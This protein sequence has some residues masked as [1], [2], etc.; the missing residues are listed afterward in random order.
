MHLRTFGCKCFVH[1]NGKDNLSKFDARSDEG[2][3][4]G[5]SSHSKAYKIYN[6]RTLCIEESA[7][8]IF[9]ESNVLHESDLQE[10][11]FDLELTRKEGIAERETGSNNQNGTCTETIL[12]QPM[13][14]LTEAGG[15]KTSENFGT[16]SAPVPSPEPN[17]SRNISV[18]LMQPSNFKPWKH[19][20]SNPID[21]I[22]SDINKGVQTRSSVHNFC[23]FSAFLSYIEP[24]NYVEALQ[25]PNWVLAM[26]EELN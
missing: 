2:V 24:K 1:N 19:Q 3:F 18:D 22:I 26:Q 9:D 16:I 21:Q 25:D 6:K 23:A 7:H 20:S 4:L 8:V 15:I 11:E 17:R 5:Y 13:Q 10:E 14:E 12:V